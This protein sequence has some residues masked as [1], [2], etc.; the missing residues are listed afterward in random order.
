MN[1]LRFTPWR[2]VKDHEGQ[3]W[4][5]WTVYDPAPGSQ[6][7]YILAAG[8]QSEA[9]ANV[10]AAAPELL[11]ACEGLLFDA[12]HGNGLQ[13]IWDGQSAARNVITKA[14]GGGAVA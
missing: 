12:L 8:I 4:D 10:M 7:N 13:A 14:N 1:K 3:T 9:E 2:V 5:I 6:N 11:R